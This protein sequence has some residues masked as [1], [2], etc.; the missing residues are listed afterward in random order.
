[1]P[2]YETIPVDRTAFWGFVD[3]LIDYRTDINMV[4]LL[5]GLMGAPS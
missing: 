5:H 1:M 3:F 2:T 4:I